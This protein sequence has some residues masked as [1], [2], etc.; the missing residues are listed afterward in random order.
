MSL[1]HS[2]IF[3]AVDLDILQGNSMSEFVIE[4]SE[5]GQAW[6]YSET[7]RITGTGQQYITITPIECIAIRIKVKGGPAHF[8]VDFLYSP[9]EDVAGIKASRFRETPMT[10]LKLRNS[11]QYEGKSYF[12]IEFSGKKVVKGFRMIKEKPGPTSGMFVEYSVDGET[13]ACYEGCK[14]IQLKVNG[15]YEFPQGIRA[16]KVRV[17][18]PHSDEQHYTVS[19]SY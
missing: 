15:A 9:R 3:Y 4:Y 19:F 8:K 14:E 12:T 13:Y 6:D 5:N 10:A 17:Y 16:R 11:G 18:A 2:E 1:S 7:K